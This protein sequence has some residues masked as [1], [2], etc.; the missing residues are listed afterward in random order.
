MIVVE[1]ALA[2]DDFINK[3]LSTGDR[4]LIKYKRINCKNYV[5]A[6]LFIIFQRMY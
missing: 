6:R 4:F 1:N 2:D 5:L 3:R